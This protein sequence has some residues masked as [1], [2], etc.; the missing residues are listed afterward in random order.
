MTLGD[1]HTDANANSNGNDDSDNHD[2]CYDSSSSLATTCMLNLL[3][4]QY[5]LGEHHNFS[6][7]GEYRSL[8]SW[9]VNGCGMYVLILIIR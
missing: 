9:I 6:A 7:S 3:H 1:R 4:K 8:L 2:K 5:R